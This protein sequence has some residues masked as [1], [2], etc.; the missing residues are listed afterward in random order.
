MTKRCVVTD[1]S[2]EFVCESK[3]KT[4]RLLT[5]FAHYDCLCLILE[6]NFELTFWFILMQK[7]CFTKRVLGSRNA[8]PQMLKG[9]FYVLVLVFLNFGWCVIFSR[10]R[11]DYASIFH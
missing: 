4:S 7:G 6:L 1:R 2:F 11:M 10:Q 5:F 8:F 9:I 3:K